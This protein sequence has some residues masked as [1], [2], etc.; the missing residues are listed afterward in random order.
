LV[1]GIVGVPCT[2]ISGVAGPVGQIT[3]A[4]DIHACLQ[5]TAVIA[6]FQ[7]QKQRATAII[8]RCI[9]RD[10]HCGYARLDIY[11]AVEYQDLISDWYPALTEI[12]QVRAL[13][14][15][16]YL[17]V[18][19]GHAAASVECDL[20]DGTPVPDCLVAV[21]G[22]KQRCPVGKTQ[23][24]GAVDVTA[25][26]HL[27]IGLRQPG[28][29]DGPGALVIGLIAVSHQHDSGKDAV[30]SSAGGHEIDVQVEIL[31]W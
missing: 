20:R 9:E 14:P 19:Q 21:N 3:L 24:D 12:A 30:H 26:D 4:H 31:T 2:N 8:E 7:G 18:I 17:F 16:L 1:L 27:L 15:N 28:L 25:S 13:H 29:I 11:E 22:L 10:R 6:A 5:G 23:R